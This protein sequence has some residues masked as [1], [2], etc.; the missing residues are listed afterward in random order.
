ML[1]VI[2]VIVCIFVGNESLNISDN[3]KMVSLSRAFTLTLK[4]QVNKTSQIVRKV[5]AVLLT[6]KQICL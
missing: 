2:G 1:T 6:C 5:A 3:R 4:I